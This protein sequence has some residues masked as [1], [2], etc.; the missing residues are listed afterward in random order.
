MTAALLLCLAAGPPDAG[1]PDAGTRA[2]LTAPR[3]AAVRLARYADLVEDLGSPDF[4]TRA[5][6]SSKLRL[7]A[8]DAADALA[9]AA[10]DTDLE[11]RTRAVDALASALVAAAHDPGARGGEVAG[12]LAALRAVADDPAAPAD[13]AAAAE[14]TLSRFP[15]AATTAAVAALRADGAAVM[16]HTIPGVIGQA[17][18]SVTLDD[19]WA[20]GAAGLTALRDVARLGRVHVTDDALPEAARAA[21]DAGE[22]GRFAVERRGK[23]FL[24]IQFDATVGDG[25]IIDNVTA[26]GPA[27]RAGLRGGDEIVAFGGRDIAGPGSLLDAI[28]EVGKL[29]EPTELKVRRFDLETRSRGPAETVRV[30]LS[31]WPDGEQRAMRGNPGLPPNFRLAP[32]R[33]RGPRLVPVPADRPAVPEPPGV[34]PADGGDTPD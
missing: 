13:A 34:E 22:Y 24:G 14:A 5:D 9:A 23:A 18:Y 27:D 2:A 12:L 20:G 7:A 4:R 29:G 11:R 10:R 8:A 6:A 1:S 32:P 30:T 26:G 25:C 28:R 15:T 17:T 16:R 33:L 3:P 19:R 21:L 31:R